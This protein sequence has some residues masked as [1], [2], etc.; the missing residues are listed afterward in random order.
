MQNY[1]LYQGSFYFKEK[2]PPFENI[3][4][5]LFYKNDTVYYFVFAFN[6]FFSAVISNAP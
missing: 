5:W 3:K 2:K 6:A 4:R 1:K